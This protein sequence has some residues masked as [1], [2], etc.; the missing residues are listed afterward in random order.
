[1]MAR[2]V[3]ITSY[4]MKLQRHHVGLIKDSLKFFLRE[5]GTTD[6]GK[7]AEIRVRAEVAYHGAEYN[8]VGEG[9]DRRIS[10]RIMA[11]QE[12]IEAYQRGD[13]EIVE[14]GTLDIIC[15][16]CYREDCEIF[17]SMAGL[18]K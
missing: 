14:N 3:K 10:E 17:K 11:M 8:L 13:I 5:Y 12:G 6:A 2:F 15:R 16:A 18:R 4:N 1:M 9:C 7:I